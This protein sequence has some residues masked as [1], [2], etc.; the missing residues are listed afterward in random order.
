LRVAE[1]ICGLVVE[2][3]VWA[4][5]IEENAVAVFVEAATRDNKVIFVPEFD[6]HLSFHSLLLS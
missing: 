2:I 3:T 1:I 5:V 6:V 4:S